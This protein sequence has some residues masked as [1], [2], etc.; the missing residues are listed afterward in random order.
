[1]IDFLLSGLFNVCGEGVAYLL[2]LIMEAL[3][4]D[5][6]AFVTVFPI[7]QTLQG[8]LTGLAWTLLPLILIGT[9][10]YSMTS[11]S[12]RAE[13][14]VNIALRCVPVIL[15]LVYSSQIVGLF[16]EFGQAGYDV[17]YNAPD[18][19]TPFDWSMMPNAIMGGASGNPIDRSLQVAVVASS[20]NLSVGAA[21]VI[22]LVLL[23]V[24]A[25]QLIKLALECVE[26]YVTVCVGAFLLPVAA[27]TLVSKTTS[28]I[29]T[30]Y[31]SFMV[32]Q[33]MLMWINVWC[34]RMIISGF[35]SFGSGGGINF[36]FQYLL[37]LA[38]IIL[39]Q[40]MDNILN[41][42]GF[43]NIRGGVGFGSTVLGSVA[44]MALAAG[45][46]ASMGAKGLK[47]LKGS[48]GTADTTKGNQVID[49]RARMRNESVGSQ[50]QSRDYIQQRRS[51]FGEQQ[52]G[53][54]SALGTVESSADASR[55]YGEM[56][57][58]ARME[59]ADLKADALSNEA[60]GRAKSA[61][62]CSSAAVDTM[63]QAEGLASLQQAEA[64]IGWADYH[65]RM[66]HDQQATACQDAAQH[67]L[68]QAA[69]HF[70]NAGGVPEGVPMTLDGHGG[71]I[72]ESP[73]M[74]SAP[75]YMGT[76]EAVQKAG[77]EYYESRQY[78]QEHNYSTYDAIPSV[79][80]AAA[81]H[82]T[83]ST[84][85]PPPMAPT[86]AA[87]PSQPASAPPPAPPVSQPPVHTSAPMPTPPPPSSHHV[88]HSAP[89][90]VNG[91]PGG[92]RQPPPATPKSDIR[93]GGDFE[94]PQAKSKPAPPP[95]SGKGR[96]DKRR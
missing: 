18:N 4:V 74:T 23:L 63:S 38:F 25:F 85:A 76:G 73:A 84:P 34:L 14:P 59:A 10:L 56:A 66:G 39:A 42:F 19:G 7:V 61:E 79:Q 31:C 28:S 35:Q 51:A 54:A 94:R 71:Y 68:D 44:A 88:R 48:G 16:F 89:A 45:R 50:K 6:S 80:E 60:F 69:A 77:M 95:D 22:F 21:A 90:P 27:P 43:K 3:N 13:N 52:E 83:P 82:Y 20:M 41:A 57:D 17:L 58:N 30:S 15:V 36:F 26:R 11:S 75:A 8:V 53:R 5:L 64:Q 62:I 55:V 70:H 81:M 40:K 24:I 72:Y 2:G 93:R 96:K 1:M 86:S 33:M 29:F 32:G 78:N 91:A 37:L 67:S 9:V 87:M 12:D 47:G 46:V 65:E 92:H 49:T